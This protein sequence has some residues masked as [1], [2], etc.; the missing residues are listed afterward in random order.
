MRPYEIEN[1]ALQIISRVESQQPHEDARVELKSR[2]PEDLARAARQI[3]GHANAAR[4]D[5]ILWL[6]GVDQKNGIVGATHEE[7]ADWYAKVKTYFD[8]LAPDVTDINVPVKGGTIAALL[9]ETTRAPYVV[10]NPSYGS[11]KG[12]SIQWEVPWRGTTSIR[13]AT[14]AELISLLVPRQKIPDCEVMGGRLMV[15]PLNN[16]KDAEQYSWVL[17]LELYLYPKEN[18]ILVIPNHRCEVT[19]EIPNTIKTQFAGA[20]LC[21]LE[22]SVLEHNGIKAIIEN[23]RTGVLVKGPGLIEIVGQVDTPVMPLHAG[24]AQITAKLLPAGADYPISISTMLFCNGASANI[25]GEW[26]RPS[27]YNETPGVR[28]FFR[29]G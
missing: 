14:R 2:W 18:E 4:G 24:D 13:S 16:K 11:V 29:R 27:P 25:K 3:A 17:H 12:E 19:L 23:T 6:V 22:T 10:K 20:T 5:E 1:W 8:G 9:F 26:I 7:M 15:N 21:S 28:S